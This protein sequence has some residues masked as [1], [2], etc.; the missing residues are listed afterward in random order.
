M[1]CPLCVLPGCV[2][3]ITAALLPACGESGVEWRGTMRDSA[4][5]TIVDNPEEGLWQPDETPTFQEELKVGTPTGEAAYQFGLI[6]G[7]DV[8]DAGR[9]F[10]LDQQAR[11][12]RV[13]DAEGRFVIE[14]GGEGAG[15]GELSRAAIGAF[16]M[17]GD[18]LLVIDMAQMRINRYL[19]DGTTLGST[20]IPL[21]TEGI[22][23]RF[24]K[25]L[26]G[27]LIQQARVNAFQRA[28]QP[29]DTAAPIRDWLL[30][31]SAG[32]AIIDTLM[33]LPAGATF[34]FTG[35]RGQ[36]RLFADEPVWTLTSD[37]KVAFAMNSAYRIEV[38]SGDGKVE[39]IVTK[40]F[41]RAPVTDTDKETFRGLMRE[42]YVK[43]GVPPAQLDMVMNMV[44]FGTHYPAFYRLLGG[45]NGTLWVQHIVSGEQ[46]EA[47]GAEFDVQNL[48]A[49]TWD[50][51]DGQGRFLGVVR[52]P[53][54]YQPLLIRNDLVYGMWRDEDDV[55]HIMRLRILGETLMLPVETAR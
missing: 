44:Q 15:P 53:D 29:G 48:G 55:Q 18:T 51:F 23:V 33:E 17:P 26:D 49:P 32:G 16:H 13:F 46:M 10:V 1:S 39:R 22:P 6:S 5:I 14:M 37:A 34:S 43:A 11:R 3:I 7:L 40:P 45:P 19:P 35:G 42:Q 36:I 28:P 24:E 54:R 9:M 47:A 27:R 21:Q 30:V 12:L 38:R 52:M 41:L 50:V 20:P 31:R 25:T 8:D 2:L 4:G